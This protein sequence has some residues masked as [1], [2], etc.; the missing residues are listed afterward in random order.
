[1]NVQRLSRHF[2]LAELTKTTSRLSNTPNSPIIISNLMAVCASILEPVRDHFKNS[3]IVHSGYRSPSVNSAVGGSKTSQHCR[4]EAADFHVTGYSVYE[5]AMWISENMDF[6][7]L[8]LENF[9]P[10][11][12]TSGWVHCSY[13]KRNRN[14]ELTKFKGSSKYHPGIILHA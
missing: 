13:S 10:N 11:I 12:K 1:M 3:I 7:Q 2:T 4:G 5:V 6:D 8:I 9:V 14:Q